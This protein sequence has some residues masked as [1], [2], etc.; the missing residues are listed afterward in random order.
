MCAGNA[1]SPGLPDVSPP[2]AFGVVLSFCCFCR[3]T[4]DVCGR[5]LRSIDL[6]PDEYTS[7]CKQTTS[8]ASRS[9]K[10]TQQFQ[11]VACAD[12]REATRCTHSL[13]AIG[14]TVQHMA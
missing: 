8:L 3:G 10:T 7:L 4:V 13:T 12:N 6:E 2:Y 14:C 11:E 1:A 9:K 5:K